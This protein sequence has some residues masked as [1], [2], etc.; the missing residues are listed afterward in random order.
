LRLAASRLSPISH[1]TWIEYHP[2]PVI[3]PSPVSKS[4]EEAPSR[5]LL[6]LPPHTLSHAQILQARPDLSGANQRRTLFPPSNPF[7]HPPCHVPQVPE[8]CPTKSPSS[9]SRSSACE[10]NRSKKTEHELRSSKP[11]WL[12]SVRGKQDAKVSLDSFQLYYVARCGPAGVFAAAWNGVLGCPS[13]ILP[14]FTFFC[15][16]YSAHYSLGP[17]VRP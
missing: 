6:L 14:M 10:V 17:G 4:S 1:F 16:A 9:S 2:I 13:L 12:P 5:L 15:F 11:T 8:P 7:G 3:T